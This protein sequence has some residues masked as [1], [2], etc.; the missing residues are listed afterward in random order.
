[1]PHAFRVFKKLKQIDF[2]EDQAV[3]IASIIEDA[4][5]NDLVFHREHLA[6]RLFD[7]GIADDASIAIVD[8]LQ[9]C[10]LS[11]Q[12]KCWFNRVRLKAALVRSKIPAKAAE[13]FLNAVDACIL[14]RR[15]AELRIPIKYH[16]KSGQVIMC[17][18]CFL[19]KPEMQKERRAIVISTP[20]NHDAGKCTV[21]PVSKSRPR[22]EAL[23]S[24]EFI[25]GSYSFFHRTESVWAVCDH[26]YTLS[27]SRM[28]KINDNR[29]P[30]L[31]SIS[32]E[33][34]VKIRLAVAKEM[35]IGID[36]GTNKL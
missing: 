26:V 16:P 3:G 18:F 2:N 34:L 8:V 20:H 19:T 13:E 27:Y 4:R 33:D 14:T 25:P 36:I 11:E 1:M 12:H 17:D 32:T 10:F 35:G 28:W 7:A 31:P 29:K 23:P 6:D 15:T 5:G 9:N 30:V 21:I 24:V 22:S